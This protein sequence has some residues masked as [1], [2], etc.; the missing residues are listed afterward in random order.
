[1]TSAKRSG[2]ENSSLPLGLAGPGQSR[3]T[4]WLVGELYSGIN[5]KLGRLLGVKCATAA[6]AGTADA[7]QRMCTRLYGGKRMLLEEGKPVA[8][9]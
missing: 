9:V 2:G 5:K 4:P 8:E 7:A 6:I 3:A 1:M